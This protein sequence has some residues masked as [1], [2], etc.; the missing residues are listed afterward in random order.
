MATEEEYQKRIEKWNWPELDA[1][2]SQIQ[3][4]DTPSWDPGKALE[5]LILKAF[6]LEQSEV[7]WPYSVDLMGVKNVEQIDGAVYVEGIHCLVECKDYSKEKQKLNIDFEPIAKLRSQLARRPSHTIGLLF[8]SGGFTKPAMTLAN[9]TQPQTILL[10]NGG[11]IDY[12]LKKRCFVQ[13]LKAKIRRCIE[14]GVS[15]FDVTIEDLA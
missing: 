9:F 15:D 10:W 8:S 14:F 12:C 3:Q 13:P 4:C 5:Y 1:L 7:R 6:E 11:E 2:W